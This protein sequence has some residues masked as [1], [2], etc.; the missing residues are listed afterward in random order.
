MLDR[1]VDRNSKKNYEVKESKFNI[2]LY[3]TMVGRCFLKIIISPKVS[4]L[5]GKYFD[6]NVSVLKIPKFIKKNNINM[7][8]YILEDYKSFNSF[9]T[10]KIDPKKRYVIKLP[11]IFISPCDGKLSVYKVSNDLSIR[12]KNSRYK[13]SDLVKEDICDKYKNGYVLVFRL[14]VDDYHRYIFLDDGICEKTRVIPGVLHTVRP[15][16]QNR[17]PVFT[18]NHREC[19]LLHTKNFND[20]YQIEV[21]ALC[22]GKIV[23]HNVTKFKRGD[24]KGYFKFG[25]STIVLITNSVTVDRD[26]ILNSK[27]GLETSV[28][29]GEKIGRK[30]SVVIRR[31]N[32]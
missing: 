14:C 25:G 6:S 2:F 28:K 24:E 3:N 20:I 22:V 13:L 18:L 30:K 8:D 27:N 11:N 21:G 4:K 19:T 7:S 5:I 1:Y 9:F 32:K 31:R 16:A 29:L 17:Y 26:I 10:R 12:I 23:N 15:I